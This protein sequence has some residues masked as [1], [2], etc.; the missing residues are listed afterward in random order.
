LKRDGWFQVSLRP[1]GYA[2]P[3]LDQCRAS[4]L[5]DVARDAITCIVMCVGAQKID[6]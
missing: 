2:L 5:F 1:I 3:H 4:H 6:E